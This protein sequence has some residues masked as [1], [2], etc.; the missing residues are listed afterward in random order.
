MIHIYLKLI[1][2]TFVF[3][4]KFISEP[5]LVI[6]NHDQGYKC[7]SNV[8]THRGNILIE[9]PCKAKEITCKYHGRRFNCE[10]EFIFM[11]EFNEVKTFP[12]NENLSEVPL[13]SWRQFLFCSL[14]PKLIWF[15][16][17][18]YG[19]KSWLDAN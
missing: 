2:K 11:P 14:N 3:L 17:S 10:G 13:N 18:G 5:L 4:D 8:C 1:L 7:Y 19:K 9:K 16:N 6:N 12:K 15:F